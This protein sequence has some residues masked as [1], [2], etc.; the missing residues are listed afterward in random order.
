[1][2]TSGEIYPMLVEQDG[3]HQGGQQKAQN[4]FSVYVSLKY[5]FLYGNILLILVTIKYVGILFL[6]CHLE[7]SRV[8]D[9]KK[10]KKKKESFSI[11]K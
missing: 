3:K 4:P 11:K 1:M 7:Q 10:N 2:A 5:L 9:N 6:L 8:E